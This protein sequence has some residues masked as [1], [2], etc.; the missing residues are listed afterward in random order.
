M[1]VVIPANQ[2]IFFVGWQK[3]M[4]FIVGNV[5]GKSN[6]GTNAICALLSTAPTNIY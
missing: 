4:I 1:V 3:E 5:G 6:E 2:I